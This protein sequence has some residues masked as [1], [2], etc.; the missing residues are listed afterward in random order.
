MRGAKQK[1][2]EGKA[3]LYKKFPGK[4]IKFFIG[5]P[6]DPTVDPTVDSITNHDKNRFL[7]SIINMTKFFDPSEC[8]VADELWNLLSGQTETMSAILEIINA[9]STPEFLT[10][11]QF[12]NDKDNRKKEKYRTILTE[13]I[14]FSETELLDYETEIIEKIEGK[15]SLIKLYNKNPFDSKGCYNLERYTNIIAELN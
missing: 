14:L 10:K 3:A 1:I 2:L 7:G 4:Q 13:W 6:F 8:L 15:N 12:I 9:L 11:L 5:F